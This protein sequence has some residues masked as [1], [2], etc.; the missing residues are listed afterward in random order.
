MLRLNENKGIKFTVASGTPCCLRFPHFSS[1]ILGTSFHLMY[2]C[3]AHPTYVGSSF[4][5][6]F[7]FS[8][9]A[10]YLSHIVVR[11]S[12]HVCRNSD[13]ASTGHLR[14]HKL[15]QQWP[16]AKMRDCLNCENTST[17][18]KD[19]RN[20]YAYWFI[21]MSSRLRTLIYFYGASPTHIINFS[22]THHIT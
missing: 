20:N 2:S 16:R 14:W 1:A 7:P 18:Y 8:F 10:C 15:W 4:P 21:C 19:V 13:N 11:V 9:F 5:H 3:P 12:R 17:A 6:A 22:L